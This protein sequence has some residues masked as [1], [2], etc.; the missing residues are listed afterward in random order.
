MSTFLKVITTTGQA[1]I[2]EFEKVRTGQRY[3][4]A[5]FAGAKAFNAWKVVATAHPVT[6]EP[7]TMRTREMISGRQILSAAVVV[8]TVEDHGYDPDNFELKQFPKQGEFGVYVFGAD[9]VPEGGQT[10]VEYPVHREDETLRRYVYL[11]YTGLDGPDDNPDLASTIHYL[12]PEV[13]LPPGDADEDWSESEWAE[14]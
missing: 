8:P 4:T 11:A 10:G 14:A 2:G 1:F 6:G 9:D 3:L 5:V 13:S 12:D 7:V